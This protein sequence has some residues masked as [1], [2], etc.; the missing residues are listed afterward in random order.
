MN[1]AKGEHGVN[2]STG[3]ASNYKTVVLKELGLGGKQKGRRGLRKPRWKKV[4][5]SEIAKGTGAGGSISIHDIEAVK[6]L[7]EQMG[8]AK[9]EQLA[10]VLGK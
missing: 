6:K 3:T 1:F 10:K 2:I 9:V 4:V 8:A 5:A 7:V